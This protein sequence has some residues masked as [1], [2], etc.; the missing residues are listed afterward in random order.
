MV[1]YLEALRSNIKGYIELSKLVRSM[2][3]GDNELAKALCV[4]GRVA[5]GNLVAV[6]EL[7]AAGITELKVPVE[8]HRRGPGG[9]SLDWGEGVN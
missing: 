5:E 8:P 2:G 6:D 7:L 9:S 3:T 4:G 1:L